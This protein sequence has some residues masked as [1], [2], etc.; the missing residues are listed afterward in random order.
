MASPLDFWPPA[1]EGSSVI[2]VGEAQTVSAQ[3]S[4]EEN[5][6]EPDA[7]ACC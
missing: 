4:L 2:V 3:A 7:S 6:G 5:E 1:E